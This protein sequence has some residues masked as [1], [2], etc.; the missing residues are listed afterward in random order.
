MATIWEYS[1]TSEV[2]IAIFA[3]IIMYAFRTKLKII[4]GL[5]EVVAGLYLLY[6]STHTSTGSG[7][8]TALSSDFGTLHF[9]VVTTSY[10]GAIFLMVR[11]YDTLYSAIPVVRLR[12]W[13]RQAAAATVTARSEPD[14]SA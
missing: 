13:S 5:I 12:L 8:S 14:A 9:T 6:L 2:V 1:Q 11:G 4:Y 3:S 10:L 7:L